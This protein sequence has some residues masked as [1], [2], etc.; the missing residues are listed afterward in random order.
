MLAI[1]S[2]F[3]LTEIATQKIGQGALTKKVLGKC[4]LRTEIERGEKTHLIFFCIIR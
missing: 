4:I 1:E 2:T 3:C